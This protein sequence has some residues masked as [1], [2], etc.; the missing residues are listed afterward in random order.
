MK[1]AL[2]KALQGPSTLTR[3]LLPGFGPLKGFVSVLK[4]GSNVCVEVEGHSKGACQLKKA[5]QGFVNSG[6]NVLVE[7]E[8]PS[9]GGL[10]AQKSPS[11]VRVLEEMY[12]LRMKALRRVLE[13]RPVNSKQPFKGLQLRHIHC[14]RNLNS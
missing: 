2:E 1:G 9:K 3:T 8:G 10:S 7:V 13:G 14:F 5:L 12:A 6:S 11:R 4:P